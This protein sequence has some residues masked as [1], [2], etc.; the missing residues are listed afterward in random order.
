[1][2]DKVSGV[3]TMTGKVF[4]VAV[5][6]LFLMVAVGLGAVFLAAKKQADNRDRH[7]VIGQP[8]ELR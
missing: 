7:P 2:N 4:A 1:M 6:L 3:S 8:S 5:G